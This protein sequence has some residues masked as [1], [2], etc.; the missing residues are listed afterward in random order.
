[1]RIRL[2]TIKKITNPE[3]IDIRLQIN[4]KQPSSEFQ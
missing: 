1:M 3:K 2:M 4:Y